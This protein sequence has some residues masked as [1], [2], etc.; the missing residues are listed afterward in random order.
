MPLLSRGV[1]LVCFLQTLS[2]FC[3]SLLP[4][5]LARFSFPMQILLTYSAD[6]SLENNAVESVG[7][8]LELLYTLDEQYMLWS[9]DVLCDIKASG[10]LCL[11][12][13]PS[14]I[15]ECG[16]TNYYP[17]EDQRSRDGCCCVGLLSKSVNEE[18]ILSFRSCL[19]LQDHCVSLTVLTWTT[20]HWLHVPS[21]RS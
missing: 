17:R 14:I 7:D 21:L 15:R 8:I 13:L 12:L 1:W 5:T 10:D 19:Y 11:L 16:T 9:L 20:E 2:C 6:S 4:L 3:A 18:D